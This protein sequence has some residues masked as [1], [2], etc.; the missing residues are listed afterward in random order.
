MKNNSLHL[1]LITFMFMLTSIYGADKI[2]P[3]K[4]QSN[5]EAPG[6][7]AWRAMDG[8]PQTLWHTEWAGVTPKHP[9]FVII[10]LGQPYDISGF[11]YLPRLGA[12][13]G[14]IKD[15]EFFVSDDLKNFGEPVSKGSLPLDYKETEIK[16]DK[17]A[18]GRYV[19]LTALSET[20]GQAF[21]SIGELRILS[22]GIL[23]RTTPESNMLVADDFIKAADP[24]LRNQYL[25]LIQEIKSRSRFDKYADQ[26]FLKES[27]I[28]ENDLDPTDV[29]LRRT[30]ALLSDIR[31]MKDAP[32]L[33]S[34][35]KL[36]AE[37]IS[38]SSQTKHEDRED[39]FKLFEKAYALRRKISF[40]NPLLNFN[41]I[42]FI[43][44]HRSIYNHMCDQYYGMAVMPG[45]G[46]YVLSD[47][48]GS[49]PTVRDVLADSVVTKGRLKGEKLSGGPNKKWNISFDGLGNLNGEETEGGN[50]LAPELSFDGKQI[51]FAYVECKGDRT[52]D[53]HTDAARGHWAPGRCYHV[54]KVNV[55]GSGLE[56]LTDGTWNDFDPCWLPNDRIAF[57][58]ERR[59]GYLRCGRACPTYTVYDMASDGSDIMFLS[60]HE[61]NE[62]QPSVTHDGMIIY[63][64]WDYVDR[65]GCTVHHPWTMTP[66][67]RDPR[68]V[69]GNFAPR[70]LRADMELDIRAIPGSHKFVATG[71]PH[72]SQAF[73]SLV[74]IDPRVKDD[75]AMA[76]VKRLTPDVWFPE[77]QG[78]T[79]SY[80]TAWPL[81]ENYYLCV[82]DAAMHING[83]GQKG[84]YGMYLVDAFG[85]KELIYRDP[86]IACQSP[87]PLR[88]R[89]KP[90]V[91]PA[92]S[93]RGSKEVKEGT[94]AV[95]NVYDA[96]RPWPDN[97][98]ITAL[99]VYQILPMTT[100]SGLHPHEIG[101][102]LPSGRDSVILARYV[103]GTA[104]VEEDG[105]AHFIVPANVELF[106]QAL[107][108]NGLAVQSMRSATNVQPGERLV[109][110]GCHEPKNRAP[111]SPNKIAMAM[112][113][114]P[115]R[116]TPDVDGTN[117]FSYPRL[118]QPVLEKHC[119]K[120]HEKNPDKA[121][122][123]SS[124]VVDKGRQ[125]FY[126]SYFSLAEKYGFWNYGEPLRTTPG[127]FGA[128]ESKLYNMLIKGHNKLELPPEDLHRIAVWLD[129][130]SIFY[131]VYEKEGGVAQ[132]KGEIVMPTLQ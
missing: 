114:E 29:I 4:I 49:N 125:K 63:T 116:L 104:P 93:Q 82:Y 120:C 48:F 110:Q 94:M 40:S 36:L 129:S 53:H 60:P 14:T 121:P 12:S 15:Y 71:A 70:N 52:H 47:A 62:W 44:R 86:Q 92:M 84:N 41:E 123:L 81:N 21:G 3:V 130:C 97:T 76:P 72:H 128:R 107:D 89:T 59:G 6:Y 127:K 124:Q 46:L 42:L 73:G 117:P 65:H 30:S 8:D 79:E 67:G 10:D 11:T 103:L 7:E 25:T 132:L 119:I 27:L 74:V 118:V 43:K 33:S 83:I 61:T 112:R 85:N 1:I 57:I 13:N 106:F 88:Q 45:G 34:Q 9:H 39:R 51:L 18:K 90:P 20:H 54:F 91:I 66:D 108:E 19:R 26:T 95:L 115:S 109:C 80:G 23:F 68:A 111:L 38:S 56:Q 69:H 24:E 131:G 98:K 35:E 5:S 50:F 16:L 58:S 22:E 55:D 28:L 64:R 77:S 31:K 37:L 32:D 78:G 102:R 2:V 96:L 113:R 75:D 126:Q 17:T 105:S 122:N 101:M 100:P 87:I 99:R